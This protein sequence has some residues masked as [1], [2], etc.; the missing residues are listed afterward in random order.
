MDN[1]TISI[2]RGC[3]N[4]EGQEN[5]AK[6]TNNLRAGQIK[7]F[8]LDDIEFNGTLSIEPIKVSEVEQEFVESNF[9]PLDIYCGQSLYEKLKD[10]YGFAWDVF[11]KAMFSKIYFVGSTLQKKDSSCQEKNSLFYLCLSYPDNKFRNPILSICENG[12]FDLATSCLAVF[13][14]SF[15]EKEEIRIKEMAKEKKFRPWP[16]LTECQATVI[17]L[18]R[19]ENKKLK[20]R[21]CELENA[22][23]ELQD[24]YNKD[25]YKIIKPQLNA[26]VIDLLCKRIC[27]FDLGVRITRAMEK[28]EIIYL[29]QL[30]S[31]KNDDLK[32]LQNINRISLQKIESFL[33][34]HNLSLGTNFFHEEYNFFWKKIEE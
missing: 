3:F 23:K 24:K 29:F 28:H 5:F 20:T 31:W 19:E 26:E 25:V 2:K 10:D 33:A 12:E 27:D 17:R 34:E 7:D 8:S 22:Q 32:K 13:K 4:F 21:C 6:K 18:L 9:V 15:I 14:K 30:I 16:T 11:N 1:K